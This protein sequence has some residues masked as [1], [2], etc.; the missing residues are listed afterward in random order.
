M[1]HPHLWSIRTLTKVVI[2]AATS[3][4][5]PFIGTARAQDLASMM[6]GTWKVSSIETKEVGSGKA[7]RPLGDVTG[8]F[9]F[10]RGGRFAGMVFSANRKAP[11]AANATEAERVAL[12]NSMVAYSGV[13][14]VTGNQIVLTIES[15]HIQNWNGTQRIFTVEIN[16]ARLTGRTSPLKAASTGLEVFSEFIWEKI[17]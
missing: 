1:T 11:A 6:V 15:S 3:F 12:F 5:T 8:T 7:A 2:L 16:G 13:Y 17:E 4:T 10:T 14:R 9:V